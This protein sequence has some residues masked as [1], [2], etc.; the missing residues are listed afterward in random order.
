MAK[1]T[2]RSGQVRNID[3]LIEDLKDF[4]VEDNGG[5]NITVN[6]GRIRNNNVI[7]DKADQALALTDDTTNFVEINSSGVA[8][9]NTS[10]FTAG[11]IALAE[12][13]TA[14]GDI[15]SISDK[16]TW[17]PVDNTAALALHQFSASRLINQVLTTGVSTK[18]QF[19]TEDFDA[20]GEYDNVTNFRFTPTL[21][22]KYWFWTGA[23]ITALADQKFFR[24]DILKNG[25]SSGSLFQ[26]LQSGSTDSLFVNTSRFIDMNGTTD[27]IEVFVTHNHGSNRNLEF[28]RFHGFIV[29]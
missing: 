7:T 19:N 18:V 2:V 3:L 11:R 14:S 13:V 17:T 28:A 22:G 20:G 16:R 24:I 1:T 9:F 12:V 15:S 10:A 6:A 8:S 25:S 23:M 27:F 29:A 5:L 21:A 4:G 26:N